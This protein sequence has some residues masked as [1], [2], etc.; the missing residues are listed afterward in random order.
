MYKTIRTIIKILIYFMSTL[1][2]TIEFIFI[3]KIQSQ[4]IQFIESS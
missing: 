2:K 1:Q 3:K 4:K